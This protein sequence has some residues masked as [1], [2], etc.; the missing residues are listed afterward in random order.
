WNLTD[1]LVRVFDRP[2]AAG[3]TFMVSDGVDLSTPEL[4]RLIGRSLGRPARLVHVPVGVL[5][6]AA[7]FFGAAPQVGKLCGSLQVDV[8]ETRRLLDW[9]PPVSVHESMAR[10]AAAFLA[11]RHEV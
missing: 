7:R 1:L 9:A 5:R 6:F 4:L 10:T 8:S 2:A 3:K 11:A